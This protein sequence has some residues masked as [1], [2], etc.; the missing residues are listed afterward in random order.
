MIGLGDEGVAFG[1][2]MRKLGDRGIVNSEL[3]LDDAFVP[4][5]NRIGEEGQGFVG[6]M[7]TF[8]KSRIVLASGC[9]GIARAAY[10]YAA[11]YAR[12]RVQFGKPI[13]EHQAVGFRLADVAMRIDA[14]RLLTWRAA[15]AFDRG[16]NVTA[17]ASMAKLYASEACMFATWAAVQTLGGWGYSREYPVEKWF[18]DAKLA[19]DLGGQLGH[20]AP[21]HL[22]GDRQGRAVTAARDLEPLFAPA[23]GRRARARRPIPSK[24]GNWLARNALRGA[25]RRPVHLINRR[26]GEID[27]HPLLA[28]LAEAGGPVET[29]VVAVP[30]AGLEQAVEE[31]LA[32]GA[33]ALIVIT[34]GLAEKGESGRAARARARRARARRGRGDARAQLHRRL[35][36]ALGVPRL[37]ERLPGRPG[38]A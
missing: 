12:E 24:W 20:P 23:L 32:Q 35:R 36:R 2:P 18:R 14:A 29:V 21:D 9:V 6:L 33:R 10:E 7:R 15:E 17:H 16:E 28:S 25:H 1:E 38:R 37:V 5:A 22:A 30:E 34:A 3:F 4:D 11:Q 8:D 31:S 19:G 13:V 26:G 27:G